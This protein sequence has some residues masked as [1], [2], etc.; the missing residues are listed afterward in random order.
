M[1]EM[2]ALRDELEHYKAEKERIRDIVGQVGGKT[3]RRRD[4][5]INAGFL[6]LVLFAFGF[7]LVRHFIGWSPPYLPPLLLLEV[8]LLL[9]SLKIIW[10]IHMQTKVGH[11]QFWILNSLEFQV[12]ML[13]RRIAELSAKFD[14]SRSAADHCPEASGNCEPARAQE[15]AVRRDS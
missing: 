5:V 13:S 6:I 14:A 10:M 8:G 2:E 7:D 9:V 3:G 12:N 1:D 4:V 11:F 15:G